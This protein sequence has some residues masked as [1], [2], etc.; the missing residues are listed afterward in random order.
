[1]AEA[2]SPW[3]ESLD[4]YFRAFLLLF[5]PAIHDDI[6]WSRPCELLDKELQQLG[7]RSAR[8]RRV[9]DKLVKVWRKNGQPAW[10]LI[11]IE[12]QGQRDR[13][14]G[15]RMY[16]YNSR[17]F[18]R[19]NCDVCSLAVLADDN[20]N[21]RPSTYRRSLWGCT[22]QMT[23]PPVKLLDYRGREA[24]LETSGNPFARVV[25]AY[26]KVLETQQN[27]EERRLWKFRLIR[28]L[29]EGGFSPADVK[30]LFMLIDWVM[31]LPEA[32][33]NQFQE[34]FDQYEEERHMPFMSYLEQRDLCRIIKAL[35]EAKFGE[36]A[37][38]FMPQLKSVKDL[39]KYEAL[40]RLLGTATTLEEVRQAFT[41]V[42]QL[43]RS[44]KKKGRP[45]Q[46][47]N[48]SPKG[49]TVDSP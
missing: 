48:S 41:D 5:F 43:T 18:N 38:Q 46:K 17:L 35:L 23:F 40:T 22:V 14:F 47:T 2:D 24:E 7:S 6:D 4:L 30:Q 8:G 44:T 32:L 36:E 3:K 25:L 29:Y 33:Q 45:G 37:L 39:D 16:V 27:L 28:G 31:T 10:V 1:M 15:R 12:V 13:T 42:L 9:V 19:Y 26:L 11:H 34:E 20:P 21:W 49:G